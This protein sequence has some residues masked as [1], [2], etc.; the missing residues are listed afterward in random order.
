MTSGVHIPDQVLIDAL[1]K[2]GGLITRA[3]KI[4]PCD[5]ETIR[6]RVRAKPE[7]KTLIQELREELIDGAEEGLAHHVR[8]QNLQ[9]VTF[10]L[11]T[12]GRDRG[13][14]DRVDTTLRGDPDHPLFTESTITLIRHGATYPSP[15]PDAE[16]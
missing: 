4:V 3:A 14:G 1:R 10:T 2:A 12:L 8:E 7:F 6:E 9:A 5:A 15:P 16:S 11:R 13:Y